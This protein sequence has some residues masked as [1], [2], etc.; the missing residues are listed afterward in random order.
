MKKYIL[1]ILLINFITNNCMNINNQSSINQETEVNN[2][3]EK[4]IVLTQI[5]LFLSELGH[6]LKFNKTLSVN[7]YL[8]LNEDNKITL[9]NF[10]YNLE[11]YEETMSQI[12]YIIEQKIS[13]KKIDLTEKIINEYY[14][15]IT[16]Q[17]IYDINYKKLVSIFH[18]NKTKWENSPSK[19]LFSYIILT[20]NNSLNMYNKP[21][22]DLLKKRTLKTFKENSFLNI[23][24]I[25]LTDTEIYINFLLEKL[26]IN[27]QIQ[28][29]LSEIAKSLQS[30]KEISINDY[31]TSNTDNSLSLFGF[32]FDLAKYLQEMSEIELNLEEKIISENIEIT[33]TI[34]YDYYYNISQEIYD[35]NHLKLLNIFLNDKLTCNDATD[36]KKQFSNIILARNNFL[37]TYT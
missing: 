31:I 11:N 24:N 1:I 29:F 9:F 23:N 18:N 14:Y 34:I 30:N 26:I 36:A 19:K 15:F 12:E 17:E 35:L 25:S 22:I 37:N 20:R 2:I 13:C 28:F 5:Q 8:N 6:S 32:K 10:D 7:D 3:L 27:T 16:A 4:L 21:N 33:D